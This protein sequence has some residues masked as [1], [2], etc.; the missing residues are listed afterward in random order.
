MMQ[1]FG[2]FGGIFGYLLWGLF[3]VFQ[4]F[5]VS[6]I[7]FT[8][9]VRLAMFP[10]SV[11]QQKSMAKTMKLQKKQQEINKKYAN[12]KQKA[13]EEM[14]KLYEK[15]G[16]SP[17]GGCATSLIPFVFMLGIF[18]AV[19][20]PLSN[21]LHIGSDIIQKAMATMG[22]IPGMTAYS[23]IPN[24]AGVLQAVMSNAGYQEISFVSSLSGAPA[25]IPTLFPNNIQDVTMFIGGFD[26]AGFNLLTTPST[27]GIF[28]VYFLVPVICFVSSVVTQL[29]TMR[30]NKS[31]QNQQGCMKAFM[32]LM[33]L[34]TAWFAYSVP[35][36]VGFYWILSNIFSLFQ[37]IVMAK[38]FGPEKV[39]A[40]NEARHVALLEQQEALVKYEYAPAI[41]AN[42]KKKK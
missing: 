9:I 2:F 19:A 25:L 41:T 32:L 24:D 33:P 37:A 13:N 18:Y 4:N 20:Y 31:M 27:Q 21:T 6:I 29:I 3:Y 35:A 40:Q 1:I 5:G 11:K 28:S 23:V 26:F 34:I 12:N 42:G 16:V 22:T 7:F 8:L 17:T 15:E 10:F 36:A 30:M 39:T 14:Q 38:A